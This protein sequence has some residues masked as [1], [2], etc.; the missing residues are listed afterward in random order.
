[1]QLSLGG[2]STIGLIFSEGIISHL[3]RGFQFYLAKKH[4]KTYRS[5]EPVLLKGVRAVLA[6]ATLAMIVI[7]GGFLVAKGASSVKDEI[8][9]HTSLVEHFKPLSNP[10]KHTL[11]MTPWELA[12]AS[13]PSQWISIFQVS[14]SCIGRNETH[15]SFSP[16]VPCTQNFSSHVCFACNEPP[17]NSIFTRRCQVLVQIDYTN[18]PRFITLPI[19]SI[20][21]AQASGLDNETIH[22]LPKFYLDRGESYVARCEQYLKL[23]VARSIFDSFGIDGPSKQP[24]LVGKMIQ[25]AFDAAYTPSNFSFLRYNYVVDDNG[26]RPFGVR[27]LEREKAE[28]IVLDALSSVGGFWT[29]GSGVFTII[30]GGSLLSFVLGHKPLSRIGLVHFFFEGRMRDANRENYP[31]FFNEG[32]Q[33]GEKQAGVVAFIREHLLEVIEDTDNDAKQQP[34]PRTLNGDLHAVDEAS[35]ALPLQYATSGWARE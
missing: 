16:C 4:G 11:V 15:T 33:P 19:F 28:T 3:K 29:V 17:E 20:S 32:G 24:I 6:H 25:T 8:G 10:Q 14:N 12:D 13:S 34:S 5:S 27:N 26:R 7:V 30:F 31:H 18:V 1:M 2:I 22:R 35:E 9:V 23:F 21:V